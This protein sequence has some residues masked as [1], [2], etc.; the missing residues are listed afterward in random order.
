MINGKC[1]HEKTLSHACWSAA[2]VRSMLAQG[3]PIPTR[4]RL[5][6]EVLQALRR[7]RPQEPSQVPEGVRVSEERRRRASPTPASKARGTVPHESRAGKT[8]KRQKM[9]IYLDEVQREVE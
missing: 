3:D 4:R 8:A 5:A 6:Q 1:N 9:R 7:L 2:A